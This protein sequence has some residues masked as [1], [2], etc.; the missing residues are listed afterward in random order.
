MF[1]VDLHLALAYLSVMATALVTIEGGIRAVRARAPGKWA[2]RGVNAM[3]L[4]IGVT[5]AA[6]LALLVTGHRPHQWLHLMYA[7]LAFGTVV[8]AD[9]IASRWSIRNRALTTCASGLLGSVILLRL[10]ATG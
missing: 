2:A 9:T 10:F 5:A 1:A 4:L 8:T 6:G 7:F 3:L